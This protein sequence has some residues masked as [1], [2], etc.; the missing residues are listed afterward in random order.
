MYN[1]QS[2]R[3]RYCLTSS[4]RAYLIFFPS[5]YFLWEGD[6]NEGNKGIKVFKINDQNL[7]IKADGKGSGMFLLANIR[8]VNTDKK[9]PTLS[10]LDPFIFA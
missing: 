9:L 1:T 3:T 5:L 2:R 4:L 6:S 8:K 7:I 10:Y